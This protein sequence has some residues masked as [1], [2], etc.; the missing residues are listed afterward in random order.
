MTMTGSPETFISRRSLFR[1]ALGA[2][3]GAAVGVASPAL[4]KP[5][6]GNPPGWSRGRKRGW[7]KKGGP[8][9]R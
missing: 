1:F 7:G 4:S 3:A 8:K 2:V 9:W 6:W 5:K